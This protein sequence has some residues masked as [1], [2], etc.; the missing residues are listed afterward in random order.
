MCAVL[1]PPGATCAGAHAVG[2][3][4]AGAGGAAVGDELGD[5]QTE[6]RLSAVALRPGA[7]LDGDVPA[8]DRRDRVHGSPGVDARVEV[9]LA[10]CLVRQLLP[11]RA[12]RADLLGAFHAIV[13]LA[14]L[15]PGELAG[16]IDAPGGQEDVRM[17]V[18][19]AAALVRAVDCPR[20]HGVVAARELG[21]ET[22]G[23]L[24]TSA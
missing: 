12:D 19:L 11:Q 13:E 17:V 18:A 14:D 9:R 16:L 1:P 6:G 2:E 10:Q 4:A 24:P 22:S 3:V 20:G 7:P 5:R 8:G 23:V 21:G 15:A